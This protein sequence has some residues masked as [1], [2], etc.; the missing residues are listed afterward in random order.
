MKNQEEY[1]NKHIF[2]RKQREDDIVHLY[3]NIIN[4]KNDNYMSKLNELKSSL[5]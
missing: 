5:I 1:L 4:E 3:D 2:E